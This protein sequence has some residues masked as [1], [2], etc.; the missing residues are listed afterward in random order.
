M[1][2]QFTPSRQD[3]LK[4]FLHYLFRVAFKVEIRLFRNFPELIQ[5][6]R[7]GTFERQYLDQ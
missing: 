4:Q 5:A 6:T 7:A 2:V 1:I 3:R